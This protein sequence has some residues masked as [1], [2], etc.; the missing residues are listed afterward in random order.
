MSLTLS[1]RPANKRGHALH[2]WL[3][4]WHSFSFAEY[5]DPGQMG[6]QALRVIN[7]D[8]IAAGE[9]FGE[10][11][12][13]NMEILTYVLEG[14]LAHKDSMGNGSTIR[15]GDVQ[16][17]SAGTGVRHSEFNASQAEP[18]HLLQIW[19]EPDAY[20]LPPTY[21]EKNFLREEKRNRLCIIAS[22]RAE[23][24]GVTWRTN[25]VLFACELSGGNSVTHNIVDGRA[26]WI[27]MIKG[28]IN[29]G[30]Q[31]YSA[32]DGISSSGEGLLQILG[33]E[34]AEFLLFDLA[35]EA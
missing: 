15:P 14:A 22:P 27:Q 23:D 13:E 8:R 21:Q 26:I 34:E 33:I 35:V 11:G 7:E 20:H 31:E 16:Y 2:G 19:I 12:H 30:E 10:H 25:T 24:G 28:K 6:F 1:I 29:I 9:G 3:E 32:G 5:Y 18:A 17:M 4:S